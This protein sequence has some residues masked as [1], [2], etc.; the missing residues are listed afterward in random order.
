[1]KENIYILCSL[2]KCC[3]TS[4]NVAFTCKTFAFFRANSD[5][6]GIQN[7]KKIV[8]DESKTLVSKLANANFFTFLLDEKN[9]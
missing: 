4:R 3:I 8:L 2:A 6:R 5:L 1:M 9:L 7:F